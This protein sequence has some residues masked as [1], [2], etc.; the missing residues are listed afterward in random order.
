MIKDETLDQIVK[1]SKHLLS[2][3]HYFDPQLETSLVAF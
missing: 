1:V 2:V 3:L